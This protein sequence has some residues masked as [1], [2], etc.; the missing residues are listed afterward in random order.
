MNEMN[1]RTVTQVN[2]Y[3]KNRLDGDPALRKLCVRGELGQY[4]VRP[5]KDRGEAHYF[6]LKD[7]ESAISCVMFLLRASTLRFRPQTGM[8]VLVLGRIS[9]YVKEGRCQLYCEQMLPDGVGEAHLALEQLKQQLQKEG[10]FDQ[11][12]KKPLPLYPHRIAVVTSRSGDAVHDILRVLGN[13]YPLSKVLLFDVHVQGDRA[14]L[15]IAGAIRYVNRFSLADAIIEGRGGGSAEDLNAFN[16]EILARTIYDSQIPVISA[17]GHEANYT[18]S[19]LVADVRGATPTH[20]AELLAP[21]REE[22]RKQLDTIQQK[23]N[24]SVL[25]RLAREKKRMELL[26]SAYVLQ[27]PMNYVTSRRQALESLQQK[28]AVLAKSLLEEKKR[29]GQA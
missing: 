21:D 13:R 28:L 9:T 12:H 24:G 26:S 25:L 2:E 23:L 6:T 15:E 27:N 18:I 10:L 19:D 16:S 14:P 1:I 29:E 17:V 5:W 7:E 22:L 3:I 20:A 11:A 4:S 8:K